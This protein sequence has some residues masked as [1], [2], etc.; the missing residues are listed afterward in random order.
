M[1]QRARAAGGLLQLAAP[2]ATMRRLITLTRLSGV[3]PITLSTTDVI[4]MPGS[5]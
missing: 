4:A 5:V 1:Q 3:L 2:T